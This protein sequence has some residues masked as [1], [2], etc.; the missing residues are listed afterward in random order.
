MLQRW[1]HD[2]RTAKRPKVDPDWRERFPIG[3]KVRLSEY[4]EG[5]GWRWKTYT[6]INY[7]PHVV[8]CQDKR[9]LNRCFGNWEFQHR[10]RGRL[11]NYKGG[12]SHEGVEAKIGEG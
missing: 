7:F 8:H 6:V 2:G 5:A 9:G 3:S 10:Q 4:L 1:M 11:E 12:G